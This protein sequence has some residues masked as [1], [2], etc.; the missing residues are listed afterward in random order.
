MICQYPMT[1][2]INGYTF[3]H[4]CGQCMSC[5]INKRDEWAL[6]MVLESYNHPA[7]VFVT[8]TYN[9]ENYP[10]DGSLNKD[11][12]QKFMKRLRKRLHPRK[13]RYFMCGEYG[14]RTGRAHYHAVLFNCSVDD[15]QEIQK[16]WSLMNRDSGEYEELGFIK[17]SEFSH[18]T[19]RYTAK[20]CTKS[21]GS[22]KILPDGR[23][24]EFSLMSRRPGLGA[25]AC[26]KFADKVLQG[27]YKT[28]Y[29]HSS[30]CAE[31]ATAYTLKDS[32]R[33]DGR[34]YPVPRYLKN[35]IVELEGA[36]SKNGVYRSLEEK[37]FDILEG[38][39]TFDE[40]LRRA[41]A[42]IA[43][44]SRCRKHFRQQREKEML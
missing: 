2:R 6:R 4:R 26:Q 42:K 10:I 36:P 34:L 31:K 3:Q 24:R 30:E 14:D 9:R 13:I 32:L 16:S 39:S 37:T 21:I 15:E 38:G 44:K 7:N 22:A 8:L 11:H 33:L 40:I 41:D 28:T 12:I 18:D 29:G 23:L 19:A 1:R 5:R 25:N 17:V 35:K 43:A 20:Y 27:N